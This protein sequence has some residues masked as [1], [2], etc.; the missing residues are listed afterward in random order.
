MKTIVDV[1]EKLKVDDITFDEFPVDGT[2]DDAVKFLREYGFEEV[3]Y[4][5]EKHFYYVKDIESRK[6]RYVVVNREDSEI[7][8]GDTSKEKISPKN[9]LYSISYNLDESNKYFSRIPFQP[10]GAEM[11]RYTEKEFTKEMKKYFA[12][13]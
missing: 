6:G 5:L 13:K 12:K 9:P 4:E 11:K 1:L 8:F 3:E 10:G 2:L 7:I